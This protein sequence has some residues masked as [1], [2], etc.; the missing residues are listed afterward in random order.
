MILKMKKNI[1][2]YLSQDYVRFGN[3]CPGLR[4]RLLH[5]EVWYI[6][7]YIRYLRYVEWY[8]NKK[9]IGKL[10]FLYYWYYYKQMG[11]KLKMSIYPNTIGPGFRIYH[12]GAYT[13][14]GP[15]VKIG[16]NCTFV[17]GVVFG[18]KTEKP[19]N[20]PVLVGDNCYFGLDAKILGPVT[21]GNNVTVG[22]NAIVTKDVPDGATVVGVNKIILK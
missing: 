17:S 4:D 13:H 9:G 22:A 7:H 1:E 20:R 8:R 21:I 11:F 5:N 15:N 14:V 2:N 3:K 10:L 12:A 16:R 19:D 6:Y 18:N